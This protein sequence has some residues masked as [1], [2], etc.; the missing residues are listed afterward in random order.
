MQF[1]MS[2]DVSLIQD[3]AGFR[4]PQSILYDLQSVEEIYSGIFGFACPGAAPS[5]EEACQEVCCQGP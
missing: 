2:D 5:G 1:L 4:T 3:E